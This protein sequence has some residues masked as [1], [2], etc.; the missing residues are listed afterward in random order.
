MRF[1]RGI[2]SACL[3]RPRTGRRD[4]PLTWSGGSTLKTRISS[5]WRF[6]SVFAITRQEVANGVDAAPGF[7][8]Y[9]TK[10][11]SGKQARRQFRLGRRQG[12]K[13]GEQHGRRMMA[14]CRV[15][16]AQQHGGLFRHQESV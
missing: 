16:D 15:G 6:V 8:G 2:C 7:L 12:E 14:A 3:S 4:Q 13:T 11:E 10:V 9:R 1:V 5:L